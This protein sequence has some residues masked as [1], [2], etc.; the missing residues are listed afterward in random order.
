MANL[1]SAP[2]I[3]GVTAGTRMDDGA[4]RVRLTESYL[5]SIEN[6]GAVPLVVAPL[7]SVAEA[8]R[9]LDAVDGLLLTGGEDVDPSRY[10]EA[11]HPTVT[12]NAERDA[13]EIAL[14]EGAHA[15]RMPTL[16]I[17]R[18]IQLLNVA[19]GGSLI[20]DIPS[21]RPSE[22]VHASPGARDAR[23]HPVEI[24]AGSQLAHI[25]GA[26]HLDVNSFHHQSIG[27][28]AEGLRVTAWAPDGIVEGAEWRGDDWWAVAVQ[29]HPEELTFDS[30][31]WDRGLFAGF[32]RRVT[33]PRAVLAT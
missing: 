28:P 24:E 22:F 14:V 5:R 10:G 18:G 21:Q 7:R 16:A 2:P 8:A 15:R 17:C 19:L 11:A 30:K 31:P 29:W 12:S 4:R 1:H 32:V 20:Q 9:I 13:T 27:R 23:T 25:V 3:I 26:T 33:A 6:A